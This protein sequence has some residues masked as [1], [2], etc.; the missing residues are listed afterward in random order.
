MLATV[1]E[2]AP[3]ILYYQLEVSLKGLS[4]LMPL[5]KLK[6]GVNGSILR[7]V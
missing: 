4:E 6:F 1:P 7:I 3:M 2:V 5:I